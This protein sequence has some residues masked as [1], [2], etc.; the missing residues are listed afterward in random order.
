MA[1]K[2][3]GTKRARFV[4]PP[5]TNGQNHRKNG[6]G[7][8]LLTVREKQAVAAYFQTGS[9]TKAVKMVYPHYAQSTADA[10]ANELFKREPVRKELL[11]LFE[12]AGMDD[13]T[14][15]AKLKASA[16]VGWGEKAT[17]KD[18]L[19]G[20]EFWLKTRGWLDQKSAHVRLNIS[21]KASQMP[22]DK[23]KEEY[24]KLRAA[25]DALINE[26]PSR[27]PR[28]DKNAPLELAADTSQLANPDQSATRENPPLQTASPIP[29]SS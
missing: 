26:P 6:L 14:I 2:G 4:L 10:K 22:Y 25:T 7:P 28:S 15:I 29:D 21:A 18:A 13:E 24:T 23:L 16:E 8:N 12:E 1:Y 19:K 3:K 9:R 5:G 11:R 20:L 17:H 27:G